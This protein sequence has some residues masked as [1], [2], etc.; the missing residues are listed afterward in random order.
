MNRAFVS[1]YVLL[2][3]SVVAVGWGTDKLWQMFNPVGEVEPFEH[4]FFAIL[5]FELAAVPDEKIFEHVVELNQ[6]LDLHVDV[7]SLDEFAQ[8]SIAEDIAGGG[9]VALFDEQGGRQIYKQLA[10]REWVVRVIQPRQTKPYLHIYKN[11]FLI[12]FYLAIAVV[13]YFWVW[14]LSRDLRALEM[15]TK[16]VGRDGVVDTVTLGSRS[17]V[18]QLA[19]AFNVMANRV[20]ELIHSHREMT[21]AVSHELRTPLARMKF[22]LEMA[23]ETEDKLK[24]REHL[25]SVREDVAD[26]DALVNQLLTYAGFEHGDPRINFQSGDLSGLVENVV[27]NLLPLR[28]SIN[29]TIDNQ[30]GD[31]LPNCEWVLMERALHNLIQNGLRYSQSK[32]KITLAKTQTHYCLAVEDDGAGVPEAERERIF[33]AFVRLQNAAAPKLSG[34]GLGLAIVKRIALWHRGNVQVSPSRWGGAMFSFTWPRKLH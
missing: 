28:P 29:I 24:L 21:Y 1:L 12:F 14:P 33:D 17:N 5:E 19:N 6:A 10:K 25:A 18:W 26:M 11:A 4:E 2:V 22:A 30:L 8:T 32:L 20:K 23:N 13:V 15:Q 9:L 27:A 31:A 16:N 7:Y 3:L 34:F